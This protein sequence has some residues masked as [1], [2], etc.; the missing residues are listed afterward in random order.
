MQS[1][2]EHQI[3]QDIIYTSNRRHSIHTSKNSSIGL[4]N[5]FAVSYRNNR[6]RSACTAKL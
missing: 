3:H 4:K 2:P 5:V 1:V 6:R